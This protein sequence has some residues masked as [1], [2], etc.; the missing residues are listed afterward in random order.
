MPQLQQFAN[1][2]AAAPQKALAVNAD[3]AAQIIPSVPWCSVP[4]ED[5]FHLCPPVPAALFFNTAD[6]IVYQVLL[7]PFDA[8]VQPEL[9][10]FALCRLVLPDAGTF[11]A[12]MEAATHCGLP[13]A[14]MA[15]AVTWHDVLTALSLVVPSLRAAPFGWDVQV[16][17]Q[18][19]CSEGWR[20]ITPAL[21]SP[22]E[23][24]C[25]L[26][27]SVE[28]L[29]AYYGTDL[30]HLQAKPLLPNPASADWHTPSDRSTTPGLA[31][32][33]AP[34]KPYARTIFPTPPSLPPPPQVC[35]CG[36]EIAQNFSHVCT[37]APAMFQAHPRNLASDFEA[38]RTPSPP[39]VEA[40]EEKAPESS[41]AKPLSRE[42]WSFVAFC[43]QQQRWE[44]RCRELRA[45]AQ[46]MQPDEV[47]SHIRA[48]LRRCC[49]TP[50]AAED[51]DTSTEK[52]TATWTL[53]LLEYEC[54]LLSEALHPPHPTAEGKAETET[55][56]ATTRT[57]T[58]ARSEDALR[59]M[60]RRAI[61]VC[62]VED[63][64]WRAE[65]VA[66]ERG[67]VLADFPV[68]WLG[69]L[70]TSLRL[71]CLRHLAFAAACTHTLTD[72][73]SNKEEEGDA[74]D[75]PDTFAEEGEPEKRARVSKDELVYEAEQAAGV[76][77]EAL[78]HI[79]ESAADAQLSPTLLDETLLTAVLSLAELAAYL[80]LDTVHR[81]VLLRAA[82]H[83]CRI[84]LQSLKSGGDGMWLPR[85]V[86]DL[87][88]RMQDRLCGVALTSDAFAAF[89]ELTELLRETTAFAADLHAARRVSPP[90][91]D[92][93]QA[94]SE[95]AGVSMLGYT[96]LHI[97][98]TSAVDEAFVRG[99]T[100]V[101]DFR[102][103]VT[104]VPHTEPTAANMTQTSA[105]TTPY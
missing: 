8:R 92:A 69:L 99:N 70:L 43:E 14:V 1:R 49:A 37:D 64:V 81:C 38:A 15:N 88:K 76:L 40:Q 84:R 19:T 93:A 10:I 13:F 4:L 105:P 51:G 94:T 46:T 83:V 25:F 56:A 24:R 34:M 41:H 90:P 9:C 17:G 98:S 30:L 58:A 72:R 71:R 27:T 18:E 16:L 39:C 47:L 21:S 45:Q 95:A 35:L 61:K 80:P 26:Q 97:P 42:A 53:S 44:R 7:S 55:E 66:E 31:P 11:A 73:G 79:G 20:S 96:L 29:F 6:G 67:A 82:V 48:E 36:D 74:H 78:I 50:P 3:D 62:Q 60:Q 87:T 32:P 77:L 89:A 75:L 65:A 52:G 68:G 63:A 104:V 59:H 22:L 12:H 5:A 28:V 101:R 23:A 100:A 57:T 2:H 103:S 102:H 33:P 85:C 86:L 91:Y 54:Q